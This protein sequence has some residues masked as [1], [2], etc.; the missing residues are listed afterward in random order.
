MRESVPEAT[1]ASTD[2]LGTMESGGWTPADDEAV[3]MWESEHA[4]QRRADDN[5]EFTAGSMERVMVETSDELPAL[6]MDGTNA[7]YYI[8]RNPESTKW[9]IQLQE[10]GFCT[11]VESCQARALTPLGSSTTYP[12][13]FAGNWITSD[14]AEKNYE[15]HGWNRI[16]L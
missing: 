12:E 2:S 4:R 8:A 11:S 13:T 3:H 6:C 16:F 1:S 7:Y 10:G 15:F 5:G 14:N 9:V